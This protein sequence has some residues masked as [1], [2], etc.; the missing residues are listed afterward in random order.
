MSIFARPAHPFALCIGKT[1]LAGQQGVD[2]LLGQRDG[3]E[4][5]IGLAIPAAQLQ[6][7]P[8]P[9]LNLPQRFRPSHLALDQLIGQLVELVDLVFVNLRETIWPDSCM[10]LLVLKLNAGPG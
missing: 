10:E 3:G 4:Q 9:G 5:G 2:T 1:E 8:G 6:R 7:P